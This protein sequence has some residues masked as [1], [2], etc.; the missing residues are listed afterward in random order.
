M[1]DCIRSARSRWPS[2][3]PARLTRCSWRRRRR[4]WGR[5]CGRSPPSSTATPSPCRWV[6]PPPTNMHVPRPR[7]HR[8]WLRS[9]GPPRAVPRA[10]AGVHCCRERAAGCA[11][12]SSLFPWHGRRGAVHICLESPLLSQHRGIY[13]Y[14]D[15]SQFRAFFLNH[16]GCCSTGVGAAH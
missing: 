8:L 10:L 15:S 12:G 1:C 3:A 14:H 16:S 13:L 7:Q 6:M 4:R 9:H 11:E 5:R 2:W